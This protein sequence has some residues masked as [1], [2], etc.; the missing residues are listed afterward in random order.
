[1][2]SPIVVGI[3][4]GGTYTDAVA[5]DIRTRAV[6]AKGKA[7]TTKEDL[8]VGVS[9]ALDAL[10]ARLV[11]TARRIALS[12]TL[13][14]NACVEGKGC[15]AKLV[16]MGTTREVLR[17]IDAQRAYGIRIEDAL[18]LDTHGSF[19]GSTVEEPDWDAVIA[20]NE[21]W[22]ADAEALGVVG[23]NALRNGAICERHAKEAL[24]ARFGIPVV[25]AS[26]LAD[27]LNMMERGATALLNARLLPVI[28][29][30][31]ASVRRAL[32]QRGIQAPVAIVRSDGSLMD[33]AFA[34]QRPVETILSGPAASILGA[35]TLA[36]RPDC[37]IVDMGGT[38]SDVSL[39]EG[40]E[41]ALTDRI[42][43]GSWKTQVRGAF[44]ETFGLGGDT[45]VRMEGGRLALATRRVEPI[46]AAA[47]RWPG[48][49][50]ALERRMTAPCPM[51]AAS[52]E[53][54]Y[55]VREPADPARYTKAEMGIVDD[56]RGG[57]A[58]IGDGVK[59]DRHVRKTD[60]LEA[61][62]VVMRFGFT[63]T[64]AMHLLGDFDRYDAAAATLAA[65]IL[66]RALG[67]EGDEGAKEL[68][69]EVYRL[70][71]HRLFANL[72][73]ILIARRYPGAADAAADGS[74]DAVIE[75][76]WRQALAGAENRT[77][78]L[79]FALKATVVGVGAPSHLLVP[80]TARL[81]GAPCVIPENS[82]VAN[83]VGA[84]A[85]QVSARSRTT[86]VPQYDAF[87]I[88]GYTVLSDAARTSAPT[89][90]A[91]LEKAAALAREDAEARARQRGASGDLR[92]TVSRSK[93]VSY[94]LTG[95]ELH[96]ETV[97]TATATALED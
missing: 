20:E 85:A 56:L 22:L 40:G 87:G 15:R 2:A 10:P 83:A 65:R 3:D 93:R 53:G 32:D 8:S 74:F 72:A 13:A 86:V 12:T 52:C 33:A 57:A 35:R 49:A 63:P 96:L 9:N 16:L 67:L 58:L 77:F 31:L 64:D 75:E 29:D 51:G 19:D 61:E 17:R 46:S 24:S 4:T 81:L 76:N 90:E 26:D 88:V 45:A 82:E 11:R 94:A 50:D 79:P 47:Q 80:E 44:V 59:V 60:R 42:R 71:E 89:E 6:V 37:V 30:F 97:V 62:G 5:F 41:P 78:D 73:R 14:T 27:D 43:I 55:L 36:D 28:E 38:T 48:I 1:M 66:G 91:A 18:C 84:A 95:Q 92:C 70:V 34:S 23:A 68:A 39:V 21:G 54:L 25:M 7:R 69:E